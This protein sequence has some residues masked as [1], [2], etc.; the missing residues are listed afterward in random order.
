MDAEYPVVFFLV[1]YLYHAACFTKNCRHTAGGKR[2]PANF[3]LIPLCHGFLLAETDAGEG[4]GVTASLAQDQKKVVVQLE[5]FIQRLDARVSGESFGDEETQQS[6]AGVREALG[7]ALND[8][9]N[10]GFDFSEYEEG[11]VLCAPGDVVFM[12]TDGLTESLSPEGEEFGTDRV[13][14]LL[15]SRATLPAAEL[16]DVMHGELVSFCKRPDADDDVRDPVR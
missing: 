16:L 9:N 8:L 11:E 1:Y 4:G 10:S 12:Y 14:S 7:R 6:L 3:Y 5:R 15:E 13:E 2:K